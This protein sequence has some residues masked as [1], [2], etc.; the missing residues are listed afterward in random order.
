MD[1]K[2]IQTKTMSILGGII[3]FLFL[4]ELSILILYPLFYSISVSLREARDLY[5][6]LVILIPR[7]FTHSPIALAIKTG[8]AFPIC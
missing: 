3:R 6:P 5:D 7:H 2:K 8:T 1:Q 4:A